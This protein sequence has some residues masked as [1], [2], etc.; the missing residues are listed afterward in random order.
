[1]LGL[2]RRSRKKKRRKK[3]SPQQIDGQIVE[4]KRVVPSEITRDLPVH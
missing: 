2:F 3:A 1:V 4:G